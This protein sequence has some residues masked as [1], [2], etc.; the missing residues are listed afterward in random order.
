MLGSGAGSSRDPPPE[1]GESS[2]DPG[3]H[4]NFLAGASSQAAPEGSYHLDDDDE[5]DRE[6][7]GD[8][9]SMI[10]SLILSLQLLL[11]CP[12]DANLRAIFQYRTH[13]PLHG[14]F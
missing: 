10:G 1:G 14:S 4:A 2:Q 9:L 3:D 8:P 5:D 11:T 12:L 7:V 13:F 6:S